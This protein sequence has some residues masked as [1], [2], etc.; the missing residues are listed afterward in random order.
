ME[1]RTWFTELPY[2]ELAI[3]S[4]V[5]VSTSQMPFMLMLGAEARLLIDL[6]LA[7]LAIFLYN[8][9]LTRSLSWLT[10]L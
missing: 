7:P 8:D 5:N 1:H 3:N 9:S 4:T 10:S 2:V 6:I